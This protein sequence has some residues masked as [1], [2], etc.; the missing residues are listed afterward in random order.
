MDSARPTREPACLQLTRISHKS[1]SDRSKVMINR[2]FM[3][4]LTHTMCAQVHF[5]ASGWLFCSRFVTFLQEQECAA[6]PPEGSGTRK[7]PMTFLQEQECTAQPPEGAGTRKC[8]MTCS[9]SSRVGYYFG[10]EHE[11]GTKSLSHTPQIYE[12]CGLAGGEMRLLAYFPPSQMS[13][14]LRG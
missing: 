7:C 10:R 14:C 1:A 4:R 6:Q 2:M 5:A 8:P 3:V 12:N 13:D 11:S 9:R